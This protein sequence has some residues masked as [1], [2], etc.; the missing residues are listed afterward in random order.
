MLDHAAGQILIAVVPASPDAS[1]A[2]ALARLQA[3][4]NESLPR[5]LYLEASPTYNGED[6]ARLAALA[7]LAERLNTPLVATN[8]VIAHAPELRPLADVLACIRHGVRMKEAGFLLDRNAERHL[9]PPAKM[10]RLF[11]HHPDAVA[12]TLAIARRCRFSLGELRYEYPAEPVPAGCTPQQ[13]L[14]RLTWQGAVERFPAGIPAKVRR[15][16]G[17]EFA[18]IETLGY[19]PYF[20]TVHDIVRFARE[21][22]ILCQGRGSAA[23]SATCYCLGITAVDPS[24]MELLFERFISAERNEPP[25]IDV[26][27]EHERRE[28]V[29]QYVYTKYGRRR[30]GMTG[31]TI[32]YRTK[33]AI[34]EVGKVLGLGEDAIVALQKAAWRRSLGE[35]TGDDLREAGL[36]PAA[37]PVRRTLSLADELIGFPHHLSQHTGGMV[38]TQGP[39]DRLAPIENAVMEDRTVIEWNKDDL[40]E[41]GILKIDILGLGMLTCVRK[42]FGLVGR[43]HGRPLDLASV[44][45]EDPAVY[46][47]LCKAASLGVFLVES[48]AQISMLPRLKPRTFFDLVIGVAIVRPGPIQGG[49]VHPYLRRPAGLETVDY[50]SDEMRGVLESTLGVPLFQEQAMRI[51]IVAAGFTPAEADQLRRAMATFRRFGTNHYFRDKFITGMRARGYQAEF[52]E[53]CFKQIEGFAD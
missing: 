4:L 17:H 40:D 2:E 24:R 45:A 32:T 18:L 23:N 7:G 14:V 29:I 50:V 16:L 22:E 10:A 52:A 38:L 31:V 11:R 53:R 27:F 48:R 42:A 1:F 34:R 41:L 30:A 15:L 39:L 35:V 6:A 46:D 47:M 12:R 13:E 21:R 19:A 28:E 37:W 49:M 26:D 43:H 33:S 5:D 3:H 25:D 9:E 51:A 44:P 36:D 8:D 20:L